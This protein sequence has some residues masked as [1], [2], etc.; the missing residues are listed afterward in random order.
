[1]FEAV[2]P[3]NDKTNRSSVLVRHLFA[4]KTSR[5]NGKRMHRFVEPQTLDVRKVDPG[6]IRRLHPSPIIT[7]F[8][9]DIL[10]GAQGLDLIEQLLKRKTDPGNYQ[11][12]CLDA[13]KPVDP[14]LLI[15][16]QQF[17]DIKCSRLLGPPA[18]FPRARPRA[19]PHHRS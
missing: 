1:A 12:P 5:E 11:G 14:L 8:K 16:L 17:I 19:G 9:C 6:G 3:W 13:S 15:D 4:V 7:R 18:D 2:L 10:C